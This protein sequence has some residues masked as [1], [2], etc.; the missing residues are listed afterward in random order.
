MKFA[1][2][3]DMDQFTSNDLQYKISLSNN[4]NHSI[5]THTHTIW[6]GFCIMNGS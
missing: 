4:V 3:V 1:H 5:H 6:F 2:D